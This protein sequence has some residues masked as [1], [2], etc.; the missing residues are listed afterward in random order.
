MG[1]RDGRGYPGQSQRQHGTF[2]EVWVVPQAEAWVHSGIWTSPQEL[3]LHD[4]VEIGK[5][6][7][8]MMETENSDNDGAGGIMN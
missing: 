1:D 4:A 2:K 7:P 5:V 6:E 8:E 3:C